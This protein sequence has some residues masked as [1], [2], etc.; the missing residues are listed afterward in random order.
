MIEIKDKWALVTGASRG[1]GKEIAIALGKL[2]CNMVLHSRSVAHTHALAEQL[3]AN[4]VRTVSLAADLSDPGQVEIL[5]SQLGNAAPQIDILY[6]NA[7]IMTPYHDD[8]WSIPDEEF[9]LSL[10]T[11]VISPIRICNALIPL[12]MERRWGRVINLISGINEQPQLAP[13]AISKAALKKFTADIVPLLKD[14]GVAMNSLD[15]GWLRTDMGSQQAP[16]DVDSVIPG[17]LV[18]ALL[19]YN[20]SGKVFCAQDYAG[21]S[22]QQALEKAESEHSLPR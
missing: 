21:L 2:G 20:V 15:P 1:I 7:A 11:N 5:L 19:P 16:N 22:I 6:N 18:P 13:Y 10:E 12:M 17:A 9:R 14:S 4:G 3:N 8:I